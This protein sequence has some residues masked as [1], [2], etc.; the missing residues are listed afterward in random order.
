MRRD[1]MARELPQFDLTA[2]IGNR[3]QA[4]LVSSKMR[5]KGLP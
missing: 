2:L 3:L 5:N 4:Q 1:A